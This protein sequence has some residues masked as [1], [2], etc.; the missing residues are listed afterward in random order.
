MTVVVGTAGHVDHGK[1]ALLR[2][3]TGIDADRLPE[4]RRRGMTIDVGYAHMVLPDDEAVDFVDVPGHD[5]LVGNMLV[6]A[7]EIDAALLVVAAD[8]GARA[9][10]F[11]HLE[12]L[13]ALDIGDAIVAVTKIDLVDHERV[14]EVVDEVRAALG[15]TTLAGSPIVAVSSTTGAGLEELLVALVRLRARVAARPSLAPSGPFRLAIDRAFMVRGR[16]LVVTGT[17]RG[18]ALAVGAHVRLEPSGVE[19]RVRGIE[20]HGLPADRTAG[21]RTALNLAGIPETVVRRGMIVGVPGA[22]RASD[23]WLVALRP[24]ASL[25]GRRNGAREA[26]PWPPVDASR[27]RVHAGTDAGEGRVG[28]RRREAVELPDGRLTAI[29][30]LDRAMAAA[31]GDRFVLRRSSPAAMVAAGVVLDEEPARGT[32]RRRATLDRVAALAVAVAEADEAAIADARLALHGA[33][34]VSGGLRLAADVADLLEAAAEAAVAAH[35]DAEPG[36]PGLPLERAREVLAATLRRV[37]RVDAGAAAAAV[38]ATFDRLVARH[39]LARDGDRLRDASRSGGIP[40]DLAAAMDRLEVAIAVAAPPPLS[41]AA[42]AAGCPPDGIRALV[43]A[44]R[45]VRLE[46]DLAWAKATY[47]RLAAEALAMAREAPLTPAAFR[48]A[49]GT[50]RKFVLAILEDLDRRGILARTPEGHV[51][52]PRAPDLADAR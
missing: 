43:A 7:G 26:P 47:Q 1:T 44:G 42:R 18:A 25:P 6:G 51:P 19:G 10:T 35:H 17:A 5:R 28:R 16:G 48:D 24:P 39:R 37:A 30:R 50:S 2:T 40:P 9:Q 29:L 11:E 27:V 33:T 46:T 31:P 14:D 13:D 20:V 49:T 32:G 4:E 52:G 8:D 45:I 22:V 12:L 34:P 38:D 15:A 36:S 41:E 23:R 21:G 3:L